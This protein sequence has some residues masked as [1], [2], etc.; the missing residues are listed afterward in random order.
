MRQFYSQNYVPANAG[1]IVTGDI[2]AASAVSRLETVFGTWKGTAPASVTIPTAP[3]LTARQISLIDKP[4]AAQ[5]QIQIGWIGVPR[6]TPDYFALRVLNTILGGSFTSRLNQNLREAHGY[7]YGASSAFEMRRGAGPFSAAAGVQ[8]DKTAEALTEFFKELDAIRK[9]IPADEVEKAKSY[10][11][12]LMP[13]NFETTE[14]MAGS[15]ATAFVYTLPADYF[16]TFTQHVRAVTIADVQHAAER[17][18][19]PDKFAVVIVGDRKVIEP[20]VKALNLGPIKNGRGVRGDEVSMPLAI[21]FEELLRYTNGER[22]KWRAWLSDHTTA[23]DAPLQP[24]GRLPTVGRLIDHI[25][26]VERRHLQRLTAQPLSDSTGLTGNNAP[27]LFDYGA[28]VQRELEQFVADLGDDEA[29]TVRNFDVREQLWPMTP[30]KLLFHILLHET[31]HWAQIALA[32]RLAVSSRQ[33]IT[34]CSSAERSANSSGS[35][36]FDEVRQGSTRSVRVLRL[37]KR[38]RYEDDRIGHRYCRRLYGVRAED[39]RVGTGAEAEPARL[40]QPASRRHDDHHRVQPA[41]R[42]RPHALRLACSVRPRVVPRSGLLHDDSAFN[43]RQDQWANA[44]AG[45]YSL[46]AEPGAET[47]T[48]IFNRAQPVFHTRYPGRP[49]RAARDRSRHVRARTWRRS[50]FTS[51]LSMAPARSWSF[52]GAQSSCRWRLK[53]D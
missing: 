43:R 48:M 31:R 33:A 38:L 46:W 22:D 36:G 47:W 52:I 11:A 1:L 51:P 49:G 12:L 3:Q 32:V 30:R 40:G 16:E 41:G 26:L 8:T 13:R 5:S 9:P 20:G 45:T 27:P 29:D 44:E 4:G 37:R 7:A 50:P 2:T 28:S 42:P 34:I 35:A 19:Q 25:F 39:A 17:Y 14:S 21:A 53:S 10:L 24:G 18:I 15:L 23:I 6:S